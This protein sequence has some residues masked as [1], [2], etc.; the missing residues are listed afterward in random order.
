MKFESEEARLAHP[1]AGKIP[2]AI[3]WDSRFFNGVLTEEH[4]ALMKAKFSEKISQLSRKL[5][6]QSI[7]SKSL[8]LISIIYGYPQINSDTLIEIA[9]EDLGLSEEIVF[10]ISAL[11]G[12]LEVLKKI[13]EQSN[14]NQLKELLKSTCS[15][16]SYFSSLP[17]SAFYF[18]CFND[19]Q[20]TAQWLFNLASDKTEKK[21]MLQGYDYIESYNA[22]TDACANGH[23]AMAQWL[24]SLASDEAEKK[25]M[26]KGD[27]S[28][29]PFINACANGHKV[30]ALWLLSLASDK[31]EK[32]AMLL[33]GM[34]NSAFSGACQGG[35]RE[36]AEWLLS[37]TSDETEKKA[38]VK[39]VWDY[40]AFSGAC[41]N[42][43]QAIAEWLLSLPFSNELFFYAEQLYY[44]KSYFNPA[45][46]SHA[47]KYL[48]NLSSHLRSETGVCD[49]CDNDNQSRSEQALKGFYIL[50]YIIRQ[51]VDNQIDDLENQIV[52]LLQIPAIKELVILNATQTQLVSGVN[53]AGQTNELLRLAINRHK[54]AIV[55]CL[56][57]I[58]AVKTETE[59]N[60]FY[61]DAR[62]I[63]LRETLTP[64]E[65]K[66]LEKIDNA[67]LV[68]IDP[69]EI[70]ALI[71][72]EERL[73]RRKINQEGLFR[74]VTAKPA[75]DARQQD[76]SYPH[77]K[78][79]R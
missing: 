37:L 73:K 39:G 60:N 36:T 13:A 58:P 12:K 17:F 74:E 78:N 69:E 72:I 10:Q 29:P 67:S 65:K 22:F 70:A 53:F 49:F 41:Q 38:M 75:T 6:S 34:Y 32:E 25:A 14:A 28:N 62:D 61:Q 68:E 56:M 64:Q 30:I 42:G 2:K 16:N 18:A 7:G 24:L 9:L 79:K 3:F 47:K 54:Q 19:Q 31:A 8:S 66:Q 5:C 4:L 50:R 46:L 71:E 35:D 40:E 52:R 55:E 59:R 11:T 45:L 20:T 23:Q 1:E 51:S 63:A 77:K 21:A 27:M 43:Y 15:G 48:S 33:G 57:T 76:H 26:V 44:E